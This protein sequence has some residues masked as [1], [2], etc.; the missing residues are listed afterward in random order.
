M[1]DCQMFGLEAWGHHLTSVLLHGGNT[2]LVF[3]VLRVAT[4]S[5]GRSWWV[6]ALFGLH[7]LRVE[8]VAWVAERKDVLSVCFGLLA[9]GAYVAYAKSKVQ[10]LK[11]KV[12][13]SAGMLH[14]PRF[15]FLSLLCFA[16]GL[17]LQPN[18]AAAR[19][20][21]SAVEGAAPK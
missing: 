21:L 3:L 12:V 14:A 15:Y 9:I 16:V 8:S 10:S 4:G 17:A 13:G 20:Q 18:L 5:A 11:S 2:V 7:P 6:A 1:G 19:E